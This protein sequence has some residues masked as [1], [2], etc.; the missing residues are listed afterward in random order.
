MPSTLRM[1]CPD[2]FVIGK[3]SH[4]EEPA[5]PSSCRCP[6]LLLLWE[7]VVYKI[8]ICKSEDN[9]VPISCLTCLIPNKLEIYSS[10]F[11]FHTHLGTGVCCTEVITK[12]PWAHASKLKMKLNRKVCWKYKSSHHSW[13][14]PEIAQ[15]KMNGIRKLCCRALVVMGNST[16]EQMIYAGKP[17]KR[18][19]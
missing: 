5:N 13:Q 3:G 7:N 17:G 19:N 4:W 2:K 10:S 8:K 6:H 18:G 9:R 15:L 12:C 11:L 16:S 1:H 14:G